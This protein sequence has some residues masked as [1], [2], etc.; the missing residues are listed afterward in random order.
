MTRFAGIVYSNS[1]MV[2]CLAGW[3]DTWTVSMF[4]GGKEKRLKGLWL[5]LL[6]NELEVVFSISIHI[7]MLFK[8][9]QYDCLNS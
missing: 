2:D 4:E 3:P 1:W 9:C 6:D 5:N 8:Y 7:S